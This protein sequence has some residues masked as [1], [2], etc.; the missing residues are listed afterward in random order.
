[1][2]PLL[3]LFLANEQAIELPA[4]VVVRSPEDSAEVETPWIARPTANIDVWAVD[5]GT[6]VDRLA[7]QDHDAVVL[8]ARTDDPVTVAW[9]TL[10][11]K[12]AR[13][14]VDPTLAAVVAVRVTAMN[15]VD[16][17]RALRAADALRVAFVPSIEG[18]AAGGS[19]FPRLA[20]RSPARDRG[21]APVGARAIDD[22]AVQAG[23]LQLHDFLDESHSVAQECGSRDGDYWHAIMHRREPDSSNSKYWFRR[24]GVHPVFP[25]L[26]P[27]AAP[28]LK[29]V[30][31]PIE[32]EW[33]P[34]AF[35]DLCDRARREEGSPLDEAARRV[36]FAEMLL[37]LKHCAEQA[38]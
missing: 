36:Q 9:Q 17:W 37:L 18:E 8:A 20:P 30:G 1:M 11:G 15:E 31:E 32:G 14:A 34:F 5:W 25:E 35:V 27:V 33:D 13:W 16:A 38:S 22:L 2:S 29:S 3:T 6:A 23:I 21:E 24:V 4:A 12:W 28:V 10:P 7:G 26:T 19:A